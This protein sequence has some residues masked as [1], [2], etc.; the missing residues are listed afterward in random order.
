MLPLE[1]PPW[2]FAEAAAAEVRRADPE[3]ARRRG[4]HATPPA[5][6]GF[7]VRSV[8]HLLQ[9]RFGLAA[10]LACSNVRLLDPAA[11]PANFLLEAWRVAVAEHRGHH[12]Q[13]AAAALLRDHLLPHSLGI[14]LLPQPIA[15]GRLAV[16]RFLAGHGLK[17]GRGRRLALRQADAL[18]AP[19]PLAPT[20]G[21]VAVVL[22]NPPFTG[23]LAAPG[24]A[25][26]LAAAWRPAGERCVRWVQGDAVR[27]LALAEWVVREHG[28]G[29][30]AL[31]LPHAVLAAPSFREVRSRLLATFPEVWALDLHGNKRRRERAPGGGPDENL[32]ADVAQGIAVVVGVR[33]GSR[34]AAQGGAVRV[35]DLW[36]SRAEKLAALAGSDVRSLAWAEARP[37]PPGFL[38]RCGRNPDQAYR[39]GL[40]LP[41]LFP[42]RSTG[43]VTGGDAGLIG[44]D[45]GRG[46]ERLATLRRAGRSLQ[47]GDLT[48]FLVR[49][50]DLRHLI[51]SP[52]LLARPR[53]EVGEGL[54]RGGLALLA[55]RGGAG[56]PGVFATRWLAGH[57]VASPYEVN[58]VFPLHLA[59][60]G[61]HG[62]RPN[63][64]PGLAAALERLYGHRPGPLD[65]FAYVY[66]LLH[67]PAFRARYRE[68]LEED[69]PRVPFPRR[70]GPFLAL[71]AAG[72]ALLA[73]HLLIDPRLHRPPALVPDGPAGLC[74][75]VRGYQ[76]GGAP[77]LDR[78]LRA[79]A[80]RPL[81]WAGRLDLARIAAALQLSL[82]IQVTLDQPFQELAAAPAA[83]AEAA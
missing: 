76:V 75:A 78:W 12:G 7:V 65:L 39:C 16:R 50:F 45:R 21:T 72:A 81:G 32:F 28:A 13:D 68:A 29:I 9:D 36:G 10:G 34:G 52:P 40:P 73:L 15:L 42:H 74:S 71:S 46:E 64:L 80:G 60:T 19:P 33:L 20:P 53:T 83:L 27:F 6:T 51:Y 31:V 26:G 38:L 69:F 5:L 67:T 66:A 54:R 25:S 56:A 57:K 22:G 11:G 55:T 70:A 82:A 48:P 43:V 23:G 4:V 18:A 24:W 35:C 62:R 41:V 61:P 2:D 30:A 8:H 47:P 77:V 17:A 58:A 49:P 59:G 14:E 44:L 63:L 37:A 3:L 79:R 1:P